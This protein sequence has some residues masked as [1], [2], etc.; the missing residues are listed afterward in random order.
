M[1]VSK[2]AKSDTSSVAIINSEA[3]FKRESLLDLLV[4]IRSSALV[5]E[6]KTEVRDLVLEYAKEGAEGSTVDTSKL[7][8]EIISLISKDKSSFKHIL[9]RKASSGTNSKNSSAVS[10]AVSSVIGQQRPVPSF[11]VTETSK[12]IEPVNVQPPAAQNNSN[13]VLDTPIPPP[14][15]TPTTGPAPEVS[16]APIAATPSYQES[17]SSNPQSRIKQIKHEINEKVGNPV[18]LMDVN[19]EVGKEYMQALLDA[20]KKSTGGVG[21]IDI[22]MG[23]LEAAY[24]AA[25]VALA[26]NKFAKKEDEP[27]TEVKK[28]EPVIEETKNIEVEDEPQKEVLKWQPQ[29]EKEESKEESKEKVSEK[30]LLPTEPEPIKLKVK[31]VPAVETPVRPTEKPTTPEVV[32]ETVSQP[33]VLETVNQEVSSDS[34]PSNLP[35]AEPVP[36]PTPEPTSPHSLRALADSVKLERSEQASRR[37]IAVPSSDVAE[38]LSQPVV[39]VAA[40]NVAA[41]PSNLPVEPEVELP[42][43]PPEVPVQTPVASTSA[44]P[45]SM[46]PFGPGERVETNDSNFAVGKPHTLENELQS[47]DITTG[48]DQL[49][50]EW[51]LFMRSGMIGIGPRGRNHPLYKK[52][53]S[54]PMSS[55]I[56]GRFEGATPEIKQ[57]ISDYMKGWRYEQNVVHDMTESFEHYLRRVIHHIVKKSKEEGQV[58]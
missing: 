44:H 26:D 30:E 46:Q 14:A 13:T 20:M 27:V 45:A 8:S 53:A 25:L 12:P 35:V 42:P 5:N 38:T 11:G 28:E 31:E 41:A 56:S 37:Q 52:L 23:R 50:S 36:N 43:T 1:D 39:S 16:S 21:G 49:L 58:Q 18:N 54:L 9:E 32:V 47:D 4:A 22:A 6:D 7:Q 24:N 2:P 15:P 34:S 17:V 29:E 10:E 51:K 19:N 40:E 48:L 33:P 55:I 3:L 57:T